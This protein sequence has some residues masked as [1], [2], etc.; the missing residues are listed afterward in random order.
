MHP[1]KDQKYFYLAREGLKAKLPSQ[2]KPCQSRTGEIYYR[3]FETN[4]RITEHPCDRIYRAK[5]NQAK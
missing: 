3:N 1:V 4:E 5:F 2:W